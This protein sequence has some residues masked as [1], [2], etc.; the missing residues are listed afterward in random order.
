MPPRSPL[1]QT[2]HHDWLDESDAEE[3]NQRPGRGA[4]LAAGLP[5]RDSKH[6]SFKPERIAVRQKAAAAFS[7]AT[8][9]KSASP[10]QITKAQRNASR[11]SRQTPASNPK[12]IDVAVAWLRAELATGEQAAV[13]VESNA[14]CAGIAPRTYDRARKRLGVTSR[15]I[16]FGRWAKYVIA[17]PAVDGTPNGASTGAGAA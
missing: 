10:H 11:L 3:P 14:R 9:T 5:N 2:R 8:S 17:L 12:K 6:D 7:P 4:R 16:G 1:K 15:R 13:E